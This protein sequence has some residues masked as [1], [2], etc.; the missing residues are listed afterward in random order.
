MLACEA[1]ASL[2]DREDFRN[3]LLAQNNSSV[4][5]GDRCRLGKAVVEI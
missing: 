5:N 2:I 4:G 1:D 3:H